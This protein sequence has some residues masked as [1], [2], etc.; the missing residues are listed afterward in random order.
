MVHKY[1]L[2]YR[3]VV[4]RQLERTDIEPLR[5]WR[6]DQT[7]AT[8]LRKMEE[9]SPTQ[10]L[11]WYESYLKNKQEI[12][13]AIDEVEKRKELVGSASLYNL[14]SDCAEFGRFLIGRKDAHGE[15]IGLNALNAILNIAFVQL[16]LSKVIL[17]CFEQNKAAF[18]IYS[19]V[20]F[21]VVKEYECRDLG[22]E[23]EMVLL[24][25]NY[26]NWI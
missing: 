20:G 11:K 3:N 23:Y 7:N 18:H 9:I 24:K 15:K 26:K 19:E 22:I 21:N 4:I 16:N 5:I 13:F 1:K 8:F 14:H 6:N 2:E 17:H 12:I 10:Q 25:E